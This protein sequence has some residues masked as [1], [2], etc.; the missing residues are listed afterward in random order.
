MTAIFEQCLLS[1]V[2][3]FCELRIKNLQI[4]PKAFLTLHKCTI[5]L[6][7]YFAVLMLIALPSTGPYASSTWD[8]NCHLKT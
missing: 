7:P 4:R 1:L 5:W 6:P 3:S 2:L 8:F